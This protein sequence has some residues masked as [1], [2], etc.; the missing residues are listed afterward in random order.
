M[1]ELTIDHIGR[2]GDGISRVDGRPVYVP[3]TLA[4]E[5][6]QVN[7]TGTRL[8]LVEVLASSPD[9]IDPLCNHFGTCGGC[10]LQHMGADAYQDWKRQLVIQPLQKAG[11]EHE[12][13]HLVSFDL[14]NRRKCV[15]NAKNINSGIQLGYAE[16]AS[17]TIVPIEHCPVLDHAIVDRLEELRGLVASLPQSKKPFR[18]SVLS[19]KNGL[20][21]NIEGSGEIKTSL[22]EILVRKALAADFARLSYGDEILIEKR[23][24]ELQMGGVAIT[25]PPGAFVQAISAAE[26]HM[27]ELVCDHLKKCKSVADLFSGIGTFALRLAE[28][29][30]VWAVE[31]SAPALAGL[32]RAWRETGGKLKQVQTESRNLDRRPVSFRE[33]KKIDGLVFDPPRAGAEA[34]AKQIA[35]SKVKK[36]AAVSCN[37]VTLA[38]DL[39]ILIEGGYKITRIVPIDQFVFTP[40]VE[41]VVLLER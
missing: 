1:T 7:G 34:Q 19:T 21:I 29:S 39:S 22:K 31:E 2:Q 25:P 12:V 11:I 9:R 15:F 37:P 5:K 32:D 28:N 40:H 26:Q 35:R 10:Q 27:A 3:F 4:S 33:L 23:K 30:T 6:V 16:R 18:L 14:A 41:V 17:E 24:P 8:E 36:L 13:E 38:R 20:D